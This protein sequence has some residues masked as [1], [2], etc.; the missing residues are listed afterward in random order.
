MQRCPC[1]LPPSLLAVLVLA[2][3]CSRDDRSPSMAGDWTGELV[4]GDT[5]RDR[6]PLGFRL[7]L[8]ANGRL[9]GLGGFVMSDAGGAGWVTGERRGDT[10]ELV[11]LDNCSRDSAEPTKLQFRGVIDSG[12]LTVRGALWDGRPPFQDHPI[13]IPVNLRHVSDSLLQAEMARFPIECSHAGR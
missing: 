11:F 10:V 8:G 1:F 4:G 5:V 3:P 13:S 12:T 2:M 6:G 7:K 9:E